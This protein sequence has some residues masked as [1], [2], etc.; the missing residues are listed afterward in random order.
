MKTPKTYPDAEKLLSKIKVQILMKSTFFSTIML[1]MKI[2]IDD[3]VPTAQTNGSYVKFNPH[4]LLL[5]S[6]DQGVGLMLHELEHVA[7]GHPYRVGTRT[8]KKWQYATDYAINNQLDNQ[9]Y[10]LPDGGLIDHDHDDKI[11]ESIYDVIEVPDDNCPTPGIGNDLTPPTD[12]AATKQQ[13]QELLVQATQAA[14]MNPKPGEHI[15]NS[16]KRQVE[17][18]LNPKLPWETILQNEMNEFARGD[19][20]WSRPNKRFMPEFYLPSQHSP[21]IRN[22]TV[23]IDTSG[24]ISQED[25]MRYM[26]EVEYIRSLFELD[27]LRLIST[28]TQVRSD[29]DIRPSDSLLDQEIKGYGGTNFIDIFQLLEKDPPTI[30]IFFTD[31]GVNFDFPVPNFK[32]I[33]INTYDE[34]EAPPEYGQTIII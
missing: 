11:A 23:A 10:E 25:F 26:T 8:L 33:W 17:D 27:R 14:E 16:L 19:Y 20:S 34:E 22:L 21:S 3:T 5:Q 9:G 29:I 18:F 7:F 31:M 1:G 12:P 30:L 2:Y 13:T 28:D 15:P 4:F 32:V 6:V 24:S